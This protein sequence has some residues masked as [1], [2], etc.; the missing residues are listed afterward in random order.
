M[1][2]PSCL[3][4]DRLLSTEDVAALLGV[5]AEELKAFVVA[6]G[7][8]G[9]GRQDP[10][11]LP[12]EWIERGRSRTDIYRQVTGRND[13]AGALEFWR[14]HSSNVRPLPARRGTTPGGAA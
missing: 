6:D 9:Q 3:D 8:A 4:G 2:D 1:I 10:S 14:A 12:P 5:T 7:T 13:M 11:R